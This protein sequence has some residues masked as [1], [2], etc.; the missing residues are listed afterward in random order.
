MQPSGS[1]CHCAVLVDTQEN[2]RVELDLLNQLGE[3]SD[4]RGMGGSCV[5]L[6]QR[7]VEALLVYD[8]SG[9]AAPPGDNAEHYQ[10]TEQQHGDQDEQCQRR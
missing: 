10:D 4:V 3:G 6:A 2:L 9:V 5:D 1:E 7:L 8:D